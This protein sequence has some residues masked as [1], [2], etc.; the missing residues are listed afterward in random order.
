MSD[1]EGGERRPRVITPNTVIAVAPDDP[2][3]FPL[4][5]RQLDDLVRGALEEDG[6]FN[7]VTTIAT[8]RPERH[9]FATIV[10]R[11]PGVIA[12]LPVAVAAFR[13]LDPNVAI[14]IDEEDGAP[15]VGG[16]SIMR[17]SGDP[18]ALLS[19][20]RVA[21]N[22]MQRL[23]GVATITAR[24]VEAVQG[25][26]ARIL[27]TRK[28]TPG[29]RSLEKYAVRAGGG[30]NHRLG[31][32]DQVLIKDNHLAVLNGDIALAVSRARE[33]APTGTRIEVECDSI[34]QVAAA[35]DAGADIVLLDNMSPDTL[36]ECVALVRRRAITEA[37]GGVTLENVRAVADSGVD[38]ISVGALT[39]SAP[40]L[41]LAMEFGS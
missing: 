15:V 5:R 21:L 25:T 9:A 8:V 4:N 17:L 36:R 34:Q 29:L 35:V 33:F 19:A 13:V 39:H 3:H 38:W 23:S 41:D 27:D 22:F 30:G 24:Y 37:S 18:R 31:L 6:A 2:L 10:A 7:D 11:S 28:T 16:T 20:E 40:A 1:G 32:S 14:R 26:H 12:G